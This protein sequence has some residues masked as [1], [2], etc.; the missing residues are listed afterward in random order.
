MELCIYPP[1]PFQTP[2]K[3]PSSSQQHQA[4][5]HS[6]LGEHAEANPHNTQDD[7]L[8]EP[9]DAAPVS[10]GCTEEAVMATIRKRDP[11]HKGLP[12]QAA[13]QLLLQLLHWNPAQR[14][15]SAEALRHAFFVLPLQ[16]N[17]T[18]ACIQDRSRTGWC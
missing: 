11:T 2:N 7:H 9:N 17:L 14:P 6:N 10:A 15:T 5:G 1:R 3:K 13:V 16:A 8:E 4:K 18:L 12:N